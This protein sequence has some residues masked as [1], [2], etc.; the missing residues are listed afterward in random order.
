[1]AVPAK[2]VLSSWSLSG[3]QPEPK[4]QKAPAGC[5]GGRGLK[6]RNKEGARASLLIDALL[7]RAPL[8]S[9]T[10]CALCPLPFAALQAVHVH[11]FDAARTLGQVKEGKLAAPPVCTGLSARFMTASPRRSFDFLKRW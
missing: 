7:A 3:L 10:L 1:M 6:E 11:C 9:F 5:E 2:H 4:L 8:R